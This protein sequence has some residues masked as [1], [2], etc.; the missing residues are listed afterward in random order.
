MIDINLIHI[1][2]DLISDDILRMIEVAL[3]T[4][5]SGFLGGLGAILKK[6]NYYAAHVNFKYNQIKCSF[7][8]SNLF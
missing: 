2:T 8:E 4:S 7:I 5:T 6:L 1:V 3:V